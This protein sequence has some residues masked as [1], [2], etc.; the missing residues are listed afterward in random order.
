MN[1]VEVCFGRFMPYVVVV[2][3]A[4]LVPYTVGIKKSIVLTKFL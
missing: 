2:T 4:C 3:Q 1:V